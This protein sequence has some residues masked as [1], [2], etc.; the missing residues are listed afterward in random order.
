M[1][2]VRRPS[3]GDDAHALDRRKMTVDASLRDL[4]AAAAH[5]GYG[6]PLQKEACVCEGFR[7][8]SQ[9]PSSPPLS[10]R[11]RTLSGPR[12]QVCETWPCSVPP[13]L[14]PL[15]CAPVPASWLRPRPAPCPPALQPPRLLSLPA[16]P[17]HT[18]PSQDHSS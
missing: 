10:Q 18:L 13:S 5:A 8:W 9:R 15:R 2:R 1:H 3:A 11:R 6:W 14:S 17:P 7:S 4:E 16:T 12:A